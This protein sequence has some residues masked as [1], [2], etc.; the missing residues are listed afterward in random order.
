[1]AER[2]EIGKLHA[3]KHL[4]TDKQCRGISKKSGE[5]CERHVLVL[6]A[7]GDE[8]FGTHCSIHGKERQKKRLKRELQEKKIEQ[9]TRKIGTPIEGDPGDFLMQQIWECAGN[10]AWIRERIRLLQTPSEINPMLT[11]PD[12]FDDYPGAST[13]KK[14]DSKGKDTKDEQFDLN[15]LEE[16]IV[17]PIRPGVYGPDHL[18]NLAPHVLWKMY[19]EERDRLARLIKLAADTGIQERQQRLSEAQHRFMAHVL[20]SV[21]GSP[22]IGLPQETQDQMRQL[23]AQMFRDA[24]THMEG[25]VQR[26]LSAP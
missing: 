16:G 23:A 14:L 18:G 9:V 26:A 7:G 25:R 4:G 15:P 24:Q 22:T 5:R 1:M 19:G 6:R 21:I 8:V 2:A 10:I 3:T 17:G 11:Y 12:L 13:K 20:L